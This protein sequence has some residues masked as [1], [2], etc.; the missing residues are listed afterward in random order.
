MSVAI[1]QEPSTHETRTIRVA[2]MLMD[3]VTAISTPMERLPEHQ[4]ALLN[5]SVPVGS[6][7]FVRAAMALAGI[8]EPPNIS[9]PPYCHRYLH[10]ELKQQKVGQV[11]GRWFVKPLTT[12]TFTG[13]VFD[14]MEDPADLSDH[15][16]EQHRAFIALPAETVVWVSG[17][18]KWVSEYRYYVA[19]MQSLD[20][21]GTTHMGL[22]KSQVQIY[23]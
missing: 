11:L 17:T 3:H 21:A 10:R 1:L 6:V 19:N 15:D 2:S 14:T 20:S 23:R 9:Y 22:M 5:G 16:Q 13:F 18:V 12:K 7:E 8:T 4:N